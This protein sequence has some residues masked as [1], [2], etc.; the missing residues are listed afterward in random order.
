MK[1]VSI[2]RYCVAF[3]FL[4]FEFATVHSQE[5][6]TEVRF[7]FRVNSVSVDSLYGDNAA[8]MNEM[9]AFLRDIRNDST[10]DIT[11]VSFCGSASP[12]GSSGLNRKLAQG[13]LLALE[14]LVSKEID[15]PDSII[16]RDDSYIPWGYLKS[17][18][19]DSDIRCKDEVTA[20]LDMKPEYVEYR[21]GTKIDRRVLELQK[22]DNG[23]VWQQM[24]DLFFS[25]MRN[26]CAVF[27]TYKKADMSQRSDILV[28]DT[29]TAVPVHLINIV[30]DTMVVNEL[31]D[32]FFIEPET[33]QRRMYI[34]TNVVGWAMAIT[35]I[36][37]EVDLTEHWSV[38]L[39][40]YWSAWN[41]FKSTLKFRTFALQPEVRY[42]L[43]QNNGGWFAGAHIG[44]GWY[45]F[46]TDG[47]YRTQDHDRHSPAIGIGV[48]AGY[49]L[50]FSRNKRWKMEFSV[51]VGAYRLHYDKFRNEPNGLLV[52]TKKTTWFGIDQIGVSA[53]YTFDLDRKGGA[54]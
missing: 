39:P 29:A 40:L 38:A 42:W 54:R 45:N 3:S 12:E 4:L 46:A 22:L 11:G 6:R 52:K 36:A 21:S 9:T 7:E 13:R 23:R 34:K 14:Q 10:V 47:K 2:I 44:F 53:V 25:R 19:M 37:I 50:P 51:G 5:C 49:R 17:Q 30:T 15:L 1:F 35:N 20:I 24:D 8:R 43:S 16:A 27:V 41:Y 18:I 26:A 33:W 32:T 28:A 31:P 48:A